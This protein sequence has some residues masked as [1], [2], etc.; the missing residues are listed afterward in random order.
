MVRQMKMRVIRSGENPVYG[1]AIPKDIAT[2]T[3]NIYYNI[4]KSGTSLILESGCKIEYTESQIENYKFED[5]V[6]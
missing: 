3:K 5:C 2:L 6:I 1:I 4:S